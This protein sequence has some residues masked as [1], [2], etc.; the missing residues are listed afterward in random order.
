MTG[1]I[2]FT[3]VVLQVKVLFLRLPILSEWI[4][5]IFFPAT[6]ASRNAIQYVEKEG[7]VVSLYV[8]RQSFSLPRAAPRRR[9]ASGSHR[10][11]HWPRF[12]LVARRTPKAY[13]A[14]ARIFIAHTGGRCTPLHPFAPFFPPT[15]LLTCSP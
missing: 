11:G 13:P 2:K 5:N 14:E 6:R 1:S 7:R 10:E 3:S 9:Q 8:L 4:V 15:T 12:H